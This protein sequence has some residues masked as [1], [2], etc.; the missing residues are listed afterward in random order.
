MRTSIALA[1]VAAS[2]L[3]PTGV[4]AASNAS[5]DPATG[6]SVFRSG[7]GPS[8]VVSR[9]SSMGTSFTDAL[10]VLHAGTGCVASAP[11]MC[12]GFDA[13]VRLDGGDDRFRSFSFSRTTVTGGT[14]D[15]T[16]GAGGGANDVSGGTG[17]D[18]IKGNANSTNVLRGNTGDDQLLGHGITSNVE[19]NSGDD[20]LVG[21]DQP[22]GNHLD[23]GTGD[24]QVVG[25]PG[26]GSM[27]GGG[28]EDVLAV[29][30]RPGSFADPWTIAGGPG[31]DTI[32]AGGDADT[33][34]GGFGSDTIAVSGDATAD[35]VDCGPG[36]DT[37]YADPEDVLSPSCETRIAGAMPDSAAVKDALTRADALAALDL[38][39]PPGA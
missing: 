16:I 30:L 7:Q 21:A 29:Q 39:V 22:G 20:L 31:D 10:Q 25:N 8:D 19:G 34:S 28:G 35:T 14:G 11:V 38:G 15:D 5:V 13:D 36:R 33:V 6:A 37:V 2:L 3:I 27:D 1:T 26:G 4:A 17:D 24:D 12:S 32:V 23:G 18:T 9:G